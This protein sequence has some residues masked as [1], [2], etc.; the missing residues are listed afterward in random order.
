MD[1]KEIKKKGQK[2]TL[3]LSGELTIYNV[4]E[5]YAEILDQLTQHDALRIDLSEISKIDSAGFQ[6]LIFTKLEFKKSHKQ[7]IYIHHSKAVYRIVELYGGFIDVGS[8][9]FTSEDL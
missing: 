5:V 9:D 2:P 8:R 3:L 1:I 6:L 7:L 4:K